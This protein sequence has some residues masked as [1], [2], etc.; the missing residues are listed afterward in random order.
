MTVMKLKEFRRRF[1]TWQGKSIKYYVK[2]EGIH[3]CANCGHD[4]EGNFCPLCGQSMGDGRI[5]WKSLISSFINIWTGNSRSMP[6]TVYQLMIRPGHFIGKYISG[7]R[8]ISTPPLNLLFGI[9]V[10]YALTNYLLGVKSEPL[11]GTDDSLRVFI[12]AINWLKDNPAW[13]AI[14]M[15]ITLTFPT[16]FLFRFSPRHPQHTIPEGATIQIFMS[17]LMLICI[18]LGNIFPILILLIPFYYYIA[19]RQLFGYN[20]WGTSWRLFL[21]FSVWAYVILMFVVGSILLLIHDSSV[22]RIILTAILYIIVL[23]TPIA[24][25]LSIGYW[26]SK[27]SIKKTRSNAKE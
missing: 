23:V 27:R 21:G 12:T 7:H 8:Q 14:A 18:L 15:T 4:F 19:Y 9:A 5:T 26:I 6:Y 10:I 20:F 16:W 1:R 24:L 25:V 13:G 22:M 17:S 3:H 2:D 11:T